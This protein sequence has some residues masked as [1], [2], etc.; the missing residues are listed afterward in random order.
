MKP[1]S[2]SRI[3]VAAAAL[4][5]A[6]PCAASAQQTPEAPARPAQP[7]PLAAAYRQR[8]DSLIDRALA[9]SSAWH[10]LTVLVDR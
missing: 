2:F 10:R 7:G 5:A 3:L 9:D 8:A 6:V 4:A 1:A